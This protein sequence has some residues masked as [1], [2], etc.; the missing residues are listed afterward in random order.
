MANSINS[1]LFGQH[2]YK[3]TVRTDTATD[4]GLRNRFAIIIFISNKSQRFYEWYIGGVRTWQF[5]RTIVEIFL[6][7]N[8]IVSNLPYNNL[9]SILCDIDNKT[10]F[11]FKHV[12]LIVQYFEWNEV[13]HTHIWIFDLKI[14]YKLISV[15]I[16]VFIMRHDWA[17]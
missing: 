9:I 1:S 13:T 12:Y 8:V 4:V 15:F 6:L 7:D 16:H 17:M 5:S 3:M 14:S 11:T 10:M 2:Y